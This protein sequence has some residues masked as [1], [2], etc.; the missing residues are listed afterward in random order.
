M[1]SYG[2]IEAL[3]WESCQVCLPSGFAFGPSPAAGTWSSQAPRHPGPERCQA[4]HVGPDGRERCVD[5]G[6]QLALSSFFT[7]EL[8]QEHFGRRH[9][10]ISSLGLP[11]DK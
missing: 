10:S 9:G 4:W 6:V 1:D 7:T 11:V 2:F 8:L 5:G 3:I